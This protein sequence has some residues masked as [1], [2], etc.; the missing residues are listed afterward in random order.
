VNDLALTQIPAILRCLK[1]LHIRLQELANSKE[2]HEEEIIKLM[3]LVPITI[4]M[5]SIRFWALNSKFVSG[6]SVGG[7]MHL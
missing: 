2:D 7:L 4:R 3:I 1:R 6:D 5:N